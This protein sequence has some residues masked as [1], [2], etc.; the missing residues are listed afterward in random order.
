MKPT[1]RILLGVL[2]AALGAAPAPA[3]SVLCARPY[4][5]GFYYLHERGLTILGKGTTADPQKM[6]VFVAVGN[7]DGKRGLYVQSNYK[8]GRFQFPLKVAVND[9]VDL[10]TAL[11]W[12][13]GRPKTFGFDARGVT[14]FVDPA[15][16]QDPT[17]S[18]Y[19]G[20]MTGRVVNL[21]VEDPAQMTLTE[22]FGHYMDLGVEAQY[23]K[24][25]AAALQAYQQAIAMEPNDAYCAY[26]LG[27]CL[28]KLGRSQEALEE[29]NRTLQ[30]GFEY[31]LAYV[32]RGR[33]YWKLNR[34]GDAMADFNKAVELGPQE[35]DGYF[36]RGCLY[37]DLE[38]NEKALADFNKAIQAKPTDP[39][40]VF[41]RGY[42]YERMGK[43][44]QAVAD[45]QKV[46]GMNPDYPKAGDFLKRAQG[47]LAGAQ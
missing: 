38:E 35:E 47:R 21:P 14:F 44:A 41:Q 46:L 30:M 4:I 37:R 6:S 16:Y 39:D 3:A 45:Y 43:Y 2:L 24:D 36:N 11:A 28:Y 29:F 18:K 26:Q 17:Y 32:D 22:V 19:R 20:Q 8:P 15:F 1:V 23:R 27:F 34:L 40:A 10:N 31:F 5:S 42:I 25:F 13:L 9:D 7:Y 12:I 33:V